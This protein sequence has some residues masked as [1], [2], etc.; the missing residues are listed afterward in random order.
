MLSTE[1]GVRRHPL[2]RRESRGV[3]H[4]HAHRGETQKVKIDGAILG[5]NHRPERPEC[6]RHGRPRRDFRF[7]R[8]NLRIDRGVQVRRVKLAAKFARR[9]LIVV[10][11][12][13]GEFAKQ[14][15]H[16]KRTGT[17]VGVLVIDERQVVR[18]SV[19]QKVTGV[20]V[21][22]TVHRLTVHGFAPRA[23]DF[24]QHLTRFRIDLQRCQN[25]LFARVILENGRIIGNTVRQ[26]EPQL[27]RVPDSVGSGARDGLASRGARH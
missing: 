8:V 4:L 3:K 13:P 11:L 9:K 22:V 14:I 10:A 16:V 17:V 19:Q 2:T 7:E 24:E 1:R 6:V 15:G 26:V 5:L 23:N 25:R 20:N 12:E 18:L 21:V 27:K